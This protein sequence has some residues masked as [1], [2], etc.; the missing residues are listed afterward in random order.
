[1]GGP[2]RPL[3][4][5]A[6]GRS[7]RHFASNRSPLRRR[8][9][10]ARGAFQQAHALTPDGI[11]G[12]E[13]LLR[14]STKAPGSV[15]P[16]LSGARPS[17]GFRRCRTSSMPLRKAAEQRGGERARLP[18]PVAAPPAPGQNGR[19]W[20]RSGVVALRRGRHRCDRV[21]RLPSRASWPRSPCRQEQR[22][23]PARPAKRCA[24]RRWRRP[25]RTS[26]R[27]SSAFRRWSYRACRRGASRLS[28]S[29]RVAILPS[30]PR[31]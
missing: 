19:P 6:T 31:R 22:R 30:R 27:R 4:A 17:S 20:V 16:S 18:S 29:P 5:P 26:W 13:T 24:R 23:S 8:P 2:R 10:A 7:R 25:R 1:M 15:A 28:W 3:A 14:L 11:A 9:Q 12:E 21:R